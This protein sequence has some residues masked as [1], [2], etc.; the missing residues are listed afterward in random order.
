VPGQLATHLPGLRIRPDHA[1]EFDTPSECPDVRGDVAGSPD[2]VLIVIV[3]D[4]GDRRFG[5]NP[6]H[7]ADDEMV[8]HHV[9][10]DQDE[11]RA[12]S[13]DNVTGAVGVDCD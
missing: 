8:E 11:R 13:P 4:D 10:H 7:A 6:R 9:A 3:F 1:H 12:E 5:R 2:A